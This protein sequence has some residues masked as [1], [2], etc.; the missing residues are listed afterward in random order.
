MASRL[1][2]EK[3]A[4]ASQPE[5]PSPGDRLRRS[6]LIWLRIAAIL[7]AAFLAYQLFIIFRGLVASVLTVVIDLLAGAIIAFIGGP[8]ANL[9]NRR[10]RVPRTLAVLLTMALGAAIIALVGWSVSGPISAEGRSLAARL[11]TYLH[12]GN[13]LISSVEKLLSQHGIHVNI[14]SFITSHVTSA[15]VPTL[16]GSL[17]KGVATFFGVLLDILVAIVFGFWLMRDSRQLR[18]GLT[19]ILPSR[20]ASEADFALD[21]FNV[22]VGGY[23]RAQLVMAIMVGAMAGVGC[24]LLGVPFPFVVALAAGI[25]ELIPLIGPFAGGAVALLLALTKS[26]ELVLY[27]LLLFLAIHVVEGYML[28]PRIQG[29]FVQLHPVVTIFALFAGIEVAGF[30]GALVAVPAASYVAVLVRAGVGDW[31][32]SRPDL[33]ASRGRN[34][35]STERRYSRILS[36]FRLFGRR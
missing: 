12:Q 21:A 4:T 20:A 19:S 10:L 17:L 16:T 27:T 35:Q 30:V 9:L 7:L 13:H 24:F 33:F 25:F 8:L 29:R 15:L 2:A 14:A 26:P 1:T 32:A 22:V 5:Q 3:A 36:R 11:P 34:D 6:A 28:V 23:V 31:R 18:R